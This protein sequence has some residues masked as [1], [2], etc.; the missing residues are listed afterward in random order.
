MATGQSLY[1]P[2]GICTG[3]IPFRRDEGQ[4]KSA[5]AGGAKPPA[6]L[7]NPTC[8]LPAADLPSRIKGYRPQAVPACEPC[9]GRNCLAWAEKM[10]QFAGD[11][12]G[13]PGPCLPSLPTPGAGCPLL[14]GYYP[15]G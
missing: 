8:G 6:G 12:A 14:P 3:R 11:F 7:E 15:E 4:I 13:W 1:F 2:K 9:S 10:G 5:S